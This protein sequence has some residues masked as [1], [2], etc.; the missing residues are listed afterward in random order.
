LRLF[1]AFRKRLA[2]VASSV[3][4]FR[5]YW[6][7]YGGLPALIFSPYVWAAGLLTWACHPLWGKV[8]PLS[9]ARPAIAFALTAIPALMA[10]T[11]AGMAIVLALSGRKFIEA[12]REDGAPDSVFM[13]VVGLFFHFLLVQTLA[14]VGCLLSSTYN[15]LTWLAG[16]AFFLTAYSITS[17]IAI[18]AALLNVSRIYNFTGGEE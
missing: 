5:I 3:E 9:G 11:L 16:V 1:S 7:L 13:K 15:D 8:D 6:K 17:A 14:L 10:F 12:M 4:P 18:A 2:T